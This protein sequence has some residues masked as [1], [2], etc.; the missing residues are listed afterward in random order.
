MQMVCAELVNSLHCRLIL[1]PFPRNKQHG[2]IICQQHAFAIPVWIPVFRG[3]SAILQWL[4]K[5]QTRVAMQ[6]APGKLGMSNASMF[7]KMP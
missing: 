1:T 5:L 6:L 7:V 2:I 3:K 4:M